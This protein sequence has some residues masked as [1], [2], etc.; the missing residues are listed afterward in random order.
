MARQTHQN[1]STRRRGYAM[2][3]VLVFLT[4]AMIFVGV[5]QRRIS[6][7]LRVERAQMDATDYNEGAVT[8]A[9]NALTLLETGLPPSDPYECGVTLSTSAG[10]RSFSVRFERVSGNEWSIHV[11]PIADTSGL[12]PMPSTF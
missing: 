8:A 5:N 3:S 7:M 1:R 4:V 2:L 6:A 11:R 12:L 10:N 9:G